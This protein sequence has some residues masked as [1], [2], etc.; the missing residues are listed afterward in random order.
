MCQRGGFLDVYRYPLRFVYRAK[1]I[2]D[3]ADINVTWEW[4]GETKQT[5]SSTGVRFYHPYTLV[6]PKVMNIFRDADGPDTFHWIPI[7]VID[8]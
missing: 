4:F 8:E 1:D 6:T 2:A 7:R 3:I 5:S